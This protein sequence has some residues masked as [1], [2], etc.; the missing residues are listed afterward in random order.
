MSEVAEPAADALSRICADTRIE[1]ARRK[2]A[3][4]TAELDRQIAAAEKPRDFA[5][6][7]SRVSP[8]SAAA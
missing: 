3:I 5:F 2:A 1:T 8:G 6:R 7:S 4:S